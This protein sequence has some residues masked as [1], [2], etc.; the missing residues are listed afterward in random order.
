M[1]N[2]T[3]TDTFTNLATGA[4]FTIEGRLNSKDVKAT[5]VSGNVFEFRIKDTG[6][7]VVRDMNGNVVLR[8]SGSIWLTVVFDTLGDSSREAFLWSSQSIA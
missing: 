3:F 5:P 4:F 7:T 8:E 2:F 1:S 6:P